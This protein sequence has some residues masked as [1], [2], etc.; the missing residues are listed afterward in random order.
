MAVYNEASYIQELNRRI[1]NTRRKKNIVKADI[2]EYV[3]NVARKFAPMDTGKLRSSIRTN[4]AK[5]TVN[6][7]GVNNGFPYVH[8]VNQ[9]KGMGMRT[10]HAKRG[11]VVIKNNF[12][13]VPGGKMIYGQAPKWNWTGKARFF[14]LAV[15]EGGKRFTPMVRKKVLYSGLMGR[16]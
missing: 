5:G 12:V 2:V 16:T 3:A 6:V 11:F 1:R 14:D 13:A 4:R 9:T 10:L 8:W 15:Q 7:R